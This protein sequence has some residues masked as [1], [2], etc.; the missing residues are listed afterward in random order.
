MS[1]NV[2]KELV[3]VI[4]VKTSQTGGFPREKQRDP[5]DIKEYIRNNYLLAVD[6]LDG[7]YQSQKQM[8]SK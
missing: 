3:R 1:N 8:Y 6:L 7:W 2:H 4:V 5:E